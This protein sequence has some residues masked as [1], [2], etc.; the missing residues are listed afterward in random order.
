M[1]AA[2]LAVGLVGAGPW[3]QWVHAPMLAAGPETRLAGVWAR[4]P[5]AAAELAGKH[6][7]PSFDRFE[8][9]LD[10]CEA[11]AFAV[12]P[13]AQPELA[14]TAARAGKAL[15]LE[16]PIAD[17]VDEARRL[18]DAVG[19]AGVGSIVVLTYRFSDGVRRFLAEAPAFGAIGGRAT[20]LSGA[21]LGGPF[22]ASPWRQQPLAALRD[23]GPHVLDLVD[24]ALGPVVDLTG[25][26]GE[27]GWVSLSLVHDS[28]AVSDVSMCCRAAIADSRTEVELFGPNG[29]LAIDA[30]ADTGPGVFATLRADFAEVARSGASHPS[31]VHR[32]LYLQELVE[33]ALAAVTA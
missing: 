19:Q 22:A 23:V 5:E 11:V 33:R 15:L 16:K 18:A 10:G 6:G 2:P 26:A 8:A 14:M 3:A 7:V 13:Q 27:G 21:F 1:A 28:G 30:R 31:D 20:F 29:V 12:A 9:L 17:S 25:R 24:A 4:R 32:G